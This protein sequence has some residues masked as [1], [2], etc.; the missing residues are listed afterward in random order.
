MNNFV[1]EKELNEKRQKRQE[2]WEKVRKPNDPKG[3]VFL[4]IPCY[5]LDL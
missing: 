4:Y 5:K 2:E 1:S 3:C